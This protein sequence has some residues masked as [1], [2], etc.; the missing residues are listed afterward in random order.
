MGEIDFTDEDLDRLDAPAKEGMR[1]AKAGEL[2]LQPAP[3]GPRPP[4]PRSLPK[5]DD[6]K[7][8]KP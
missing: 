7:I 2:N 4:A 5:L 8:T 1:R 3:K 6:S